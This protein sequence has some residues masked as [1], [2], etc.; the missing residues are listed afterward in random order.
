M[1]M[2]TSNSVTQKGCTEGSTRKLTG[3]VAGMVLVV[4]HTEGRNQ[5][6]IVLLDWCLIVFHTQRFLLDTFVV[7]L[8]MFNQQLF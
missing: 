7:I 5:H 6:C 8:T 3:L 1:G 2:P 4:I